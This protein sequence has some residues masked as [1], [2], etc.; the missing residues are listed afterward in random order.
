MV[1]LRVLDKGSLG[2]EVLATEG[3]GEVSAACMLLH[4]NLQVV[5][6]FKH[7]PTNFTG[8]TFFPPVT[9]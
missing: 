7:F 6:L 5:R 9:F 8:E 1:P 3:A 4:V 2:H